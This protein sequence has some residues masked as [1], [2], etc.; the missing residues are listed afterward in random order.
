MVATQGCLVCFAI[1]VCRYAPPR[2]RKQGIHKR[3]CI[4]TNTQLRLC[5]LCCSLPF[6][7]V[8]QVP[9]RAAAFLRELLLVS[10]NQARQALLRRMFSEDW[11]VLPE[12][13]D[14][15][16]VRAVCV[17]LSAPK[18]IRLCACESRV[19]NLIKS[20]STTSSNYYVPT[21]SSGGS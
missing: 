5:V 20:R 13:P 6:S 10:D 16:Q 3:L 19:E 15:W 11:E 4:C 12:S 18:R 8:C 2:C 21:P 7:P 17:R 14:C 1:G 9:K